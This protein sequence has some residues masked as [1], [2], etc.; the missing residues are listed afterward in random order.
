M[1]SDCLVGFTT[2]MYI[3]LVTISIEYFG[4]MYISLRW[5]G[6]EVRRP[7]VM[8]NFYGFTVL[9]VYVVAAVIFVSVKPL[10]D[11]S[12]LGGELK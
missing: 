12:C 9:L 8:Y 3:F 4:T 1:W 2:I 7:F 5:G 11:G 6:D 10:K